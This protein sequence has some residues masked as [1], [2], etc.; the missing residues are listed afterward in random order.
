MRFFAVALISL[1]A[2]SDAFAPALH[3]RHISA[4]GATNNDW[5]PKTTQLRQK[6][7]R[8]GKGLK[9]GVAAVAFASLAFRQPRDAQ[10][11]TME[12]V[13][14]VSRTEEQDT[15][16]PNKVFPVVTAVVGAA[17]VGTVVA[18]YV[19]KRRESEEL[20]EEFEEEVEEE[21]EEE[22]ASLSLQKT[23]KPTSDEPSE[24]PSSKTDEPPADK[25]SKSPAA[26]VV[27][28][29]AVRISEEN[30]KVLEKEK[31]AAVLEKVKDAEKKA[32]EAKVKATP[33]PPA[34]KKEE[35][36]PVATLEKE[37]ETNPAPAALAKV[38]DAENKAL[39]AE[40]KATPPPPTPKEKELAPIATLEKEVETGPA[41]V[42]TLEP[43]KPVPTPP[44][45][46]A[47]KEPVA[48]K[49]LPVKKEAVVED[50]PTETFTSAEK[51]KIAD[52][53]FDCHGFIP[54]LRPESELSSE[55]RKMRQQ[56]KAAGE[57]RLIKQKYEAIEDES[58]RVY[59]MLVDLGMM[60]SYDHL[61]EY[62]DDFDDEEL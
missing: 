9:R 11:S 36:A 2:T 21:K 34:P 60:E 39:E 55:V 20:I 25:P 52:N 48:V 50:D 58:E 43:P 62:T 31:I 19:I 23:I 26:K 3:A 1:L 32:L 47:K 54:D 4:L 45:P 7:K 37:I 59:T 46:A 51:V 14:S 10:A 15:S 22:K 41:P 28:E 27:E 16:S 5:G 57:L 8:A 33:P 49:P 40:V 53:V 44:K 42:A 35:P 13:P 6:M 56:P 38:K 18:K 17:G 30:A 12:L 61:D 24:T 29:A